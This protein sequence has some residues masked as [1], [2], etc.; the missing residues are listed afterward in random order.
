[1]PNNPPVD[2]FVD[3]AKTDNGTIYFYV[4]DGAGDALAASM[5]R[6]QMAAEQKQQQNAQTFM[7]T[8]EKHQSLA[9]DPIT[10]TA[11]I[12]AIAG[13]VGT[14]AAVGGTAAAVGSLG[15]GVAGTAMNFASAMK[16]S[17]DNNY[18][19]LAS[20]EV[21]FKNEILGPL[22]PTYYGTN[23]CSTASSCMPI[24]PGNSTSV[25]LMQPNGF[26][27]DEAS[28]FQN[29]TVG[30]PAYLDPDSGE[31]V[32]TLTTS[33]SLQFSYTSSGDWQP[34]YKI[35]GMTDYGT[36]SGLGVSAIYFQPD[37]GVEMLDFTIMSS[38]MQKS[39][40]AMQAAFLP[41]SSQIH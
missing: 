34:A 26:D 15:V 32:E 28:Y 7:R 6:V 23:G 5:A 24:L 10:V 18:K 33:V 20:A 35:D 22:V 30:A 37:E 21:T 11:V 13:T 17:G 4:G 3:S 8:L 40:G 38:Q 14:V 9:I 27:K 36:H 12:G 29:F 31:I 25:T 39:T 1:M 2:G 19:P 41:G 16:A